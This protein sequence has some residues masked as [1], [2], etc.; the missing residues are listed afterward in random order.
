MYQSWKK[1]KDK[2]EDKKSYLHPEKNNCKEIFF[3]W[4]KNIICLFFKFV[5]HIGVQLIYS[6]VLVSGG[7]QSDSVIHIHVS[8]MPSGNS[9]LSLT[10]SAITKMPLERLEIVPTLI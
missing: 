2:L 6:D 9:P 5:F 4:R 1:P 8:L 3:F 7:Q 10:T